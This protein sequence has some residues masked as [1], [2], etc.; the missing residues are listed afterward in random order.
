MQTLKKLYHTE[1]ELLPFF[2]ILSWMLEGPFFR[3][4]EPLNTLQYHP[5][6]ICF[7]INYW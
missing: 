1:I 2:L 5:F 6:E 4:K 3:I 7:P